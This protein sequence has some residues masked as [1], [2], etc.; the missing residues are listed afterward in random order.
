[1]D[2]THLAKRPRPSS[3][4]DQELAG[5]LDARERA[6][7]ARDFATADRIRSELREAGVELIDAE[8]K[9]R[10]ADGREGAITAAAV[11]RA[12][13]STVHCDLSDEAI[14][15]QVTA[16]EGARQQRDW[17][18]ADQVRDALRARGVDVL[19]KERIWR[20][21]D[22]RVGLLTSHLQD[23]EIAALVALR[24]QERSAR[25]FDLADRLRVLA[26]QAGV[27]LDDK[28]GTWTAD[29]GRYGTLRAAAAAPPNPY[30]A[31]VSPYAPPN[32]YAAPPN[33]YAAQPHYAPPPG[34]APVY[35]AP[36]PAAAAA[37]SGA[38]GGTLLELEILAIVRAHEEATGRG[39]GAVQRAFG[40]LLSARGIE[41]DESAGVWRA[42][43]GRQG[44][45]RH[46]EDDGGRAAYSAAL[47][48]AAGASGAAAGG[49]AA[50]EAAGAGDDIEALLQLREQARA[51]RNF[52]VA[53][54]IRDQLRSR[55]IALDDALSTWSSPDG[56]GGKYPPGTTAL[57]GPPL[58][59]EEISALVAQREQARRNRDY[60]AAD[61]LRTR[62]RTS[63][64]D[65]LD[66]EKLWRAADGRTGAI[67]D[68]PYAV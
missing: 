64:V 9:W 51:Q 24:E 34:V 17:H 68:A 31:P 5:Q 41:L 18:T 28:S 27:R 48:A 62:L 57:A 23:A 6:R 13:A 60:A 3:L 16:R 10:T 39:D 15:Q 4:T 2:Y 35:V 63:G 42:A 30:A 52:A 20:S 50:G 29:D 1:M 46:G 8:N 53:D 59:A 25:N 54:R 26:N 40:A 66:R 65:I 19:D 55:S 38:H 56:R 43:D 58:S 47:T 44:A 12:S 14:V 67:T 32:P 61:A 22:G 36:P 37:P 49:A 21:S 45:L 33:P 11:A 7:A